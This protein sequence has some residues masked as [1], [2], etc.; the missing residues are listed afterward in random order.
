MIAAAKERSRFPESAVPNRR[1]PHWGWCHDEETGGE[2]DGNHQQQG[3]DDALEQTLTAP[4]LDRQQQQ[5]DHP[6]DDPADRQRQVEH[7]PQCDSSADHFGHI[8]CHRDDLGLCPVG[9]P[10]RASHS[11]ADRFR[12]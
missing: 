1:G 5:R 3:G 6:G 12:Q 9:Q 4:I 11:L 2:A 7:D 10:G 8:G